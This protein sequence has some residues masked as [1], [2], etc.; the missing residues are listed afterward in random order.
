MVKS[1][2]L[3]GGNLKYV[4]LDACY[5]D[6]EEIE[7]F[8]SATETLW[9]LVESSP[10][11]LTTKVQENV[12]SEHGKLEAELKVRDKERVEFTNIINDLKI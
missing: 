6:D 1:K 5:N 3:K 8:K 11:L 10:K 12:Q 9:T 7:A 2:F 4:F